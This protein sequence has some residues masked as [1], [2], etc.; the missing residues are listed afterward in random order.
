VGHPGGSGGYRDLCR[1]LIHPV[2]DYESDRDS[3]TDGV[4]LMFAGLFGLTGCVVGR[5]DSESLRIIPITEVHRM[6]DKGFPLNLFQNKT[7]TI[8]PDSPLIYS[9]GQPSYHAI[10]FSNRLSIPDY[11]NGKP[12]ALVCPDDRPCFQCDHEAARR[13]ARLYV[14]GKWDGA[15]VFLPLNK[16]P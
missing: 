7:R 2:R 14:R 5:L 13:Y 3:M 10:K 8:S 11:R 6:D 4:L 1:S 16:E 12:N 15:I 9:E